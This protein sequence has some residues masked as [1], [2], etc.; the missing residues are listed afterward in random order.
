MVKI[1]RVR[2][3]RSIGGR[4]AELLDV[5]SDA[6]RRDLRE[7]QAALITPVEE[8]FYCARIGRAR[9]AVANVGGKEFDEAAAGAFAPSANDRRQ[10]I[11]SGPDESRRRRD[12]VS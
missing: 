12:F 9:V 6:E 1:H 4:G 3:V 2:F 8:L 7:I 5:G 11:E 10:G